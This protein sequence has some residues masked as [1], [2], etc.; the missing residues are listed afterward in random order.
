MEILLP[1]PQG[2][3]EL[4]ISASEL[5]PFQPDSRNKVKVTGVLRPR[6]PMSV[7]LLDRRI[8]EPEHCFARASLQGSIRAEKSEKG[9]VERSVNE[10]V[11]PIRTLPPKP[12]WDHVLGQQS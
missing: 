1:T 12:A 2:L 9:S 3:N 6:C 4:V 8:C 5:P 10:Q 7:Y 11:S